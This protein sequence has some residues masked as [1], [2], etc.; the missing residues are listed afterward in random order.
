VKFTVTGWVMVAVVSF[1]GILLPDLLHEKRQ[2][3]KKH[4][5][6]ILTMWLCMLLLKW[7]VMLIV[8]V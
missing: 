2:D 4:N 6:P 8:I 1:T 5:N 3:I 7:V